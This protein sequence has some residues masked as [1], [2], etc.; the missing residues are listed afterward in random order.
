MSNIVKFP[1]DR[2]PRVRDIVR[3]DPDVLKNARID[4]T[5]SLDDLVD[6]IRRAIDE[7]AEADEDTAMFIAAAVRC[8]FLGIEVHR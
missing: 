5:S 4:T 2:Q 3:Y 6:V 7:A 8:W 1:R